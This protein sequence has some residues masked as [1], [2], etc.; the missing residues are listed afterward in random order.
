M[1]LS[2]PLTASTSCIDA[3]GLNKLADLFSYYY[4]GHDKLQRLFYNTRHSISQP[5][6]Y[7]RPQPLFHL[8]NHKATQATDATQS[9]NLIVTDD[10][11]GSET[12]LAKAPSK[13]ITSQQQ[14]KF[15]GGSRQNQSKRQKEWIYLCHYIA[16]S[17]LNPLHIISGQD[18][19]QEPDFTL[20]FY[21][22]S[23]LYYVGVELTTLPRLRDQMGDKALIGKR[24]YWQ[25]LQVMAKQRQ[26]MASYQRFKLPIQTIYMPSAE[27]DRRWRQL[28]HSIISQDDINAVMQKKAHKVVGYHTR[29]P[30]DELWLLVHT[31]KYQP[32]S[33]LTSAKKPLVLYHTSGFDQVHV[34]RYPSHKIIN[35][36]K[37]KAES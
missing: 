20:I 34:T 1:I 36:A 25:A 32:N 9:Y 11:A 15:T 21:Q 10:I 19:G 5:T 6:G 26:K 13:A 22:Q 37:L 23:R 30:L 24:W 29:R 4:C 2:I 3:H 14:Y 18:D 27:Y 33:I 31:D 12:S 7:Y 8:T 28:P 35:V 16:I 17:G